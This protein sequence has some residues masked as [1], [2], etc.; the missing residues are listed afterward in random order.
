MRI[1]CNHPH[2]G[3][4]MEIRDSYNYLG[5]IF[6][7]QRKIDECRDNNLQEELSMLLKKLQFQLLTSGENNIS[8]LNSLPQRVFWKNMQRKY[9]GC[10]TLVASDAGL[11]DPAKIIGK[12]DEEI[13][14]NF[15]EE[16]YRNDDEW[17]LK[18]GLS[19]YN[20]LQ[21]VHTT[22]GSKFFLCN[23]IPLRDGNGKLVGI[24]GSLEDLTEFWGGNELVY[25]VTPQ[26]R[27]EDR[28]MANDERFVNKEKFIPGHTEIQKS[29]EGSLEILQEMNVWSGSIDCYKSEIGEFLLSD[30]LS[31]DQLQ[32]MQDAFAQANQVASIIT[33]PEGTPLT[34]PSNFSELCTQIRQ[35]EKGRQNCNF[36]DKCLGKKSFV[37]MTPVYGKCKGCGLIDGCAPIVIAGV[38]IANWII[39][40]N[41]IGDVTE[42]DILYY[43]IEIGANKIKM[44][45]A[46]TKMKQVSAK[47]FHDSLH[48]LWIMAKEIG[49]MGYKNLKLAKDIELRKVVEERY[50]QAK[51]K[52]E[53]SDRLK[54][55]FLANMSHE[56]R[57]PM[58]GILGFTALLNNPRLN[59]N[60]RNEY[61]NLVNSSSQTLLNLIDDI[62]DISKIETG[63]LIIHENKCNLYQLLHQLFGIFKD[64]V[65]LKE[66]NLD[67]TIKVAESLQDL[68]IICD[69]ARLRQIFSNLLSNA[70]KFTEKGSIEF[71]YSL[72][73]SANGRDNNGS[74][75]LFFVKDSG[76]GIHDDQIPLIFDVFRQI[77]DSYTRKVGGTGLGL[78][79]S[80]NLV[81]MLGGEI[82]VD[83][84][85]ELG[86]TFY[87]TIPFHKGERNS[88]SMTP[89][90]LIGRENNINWEKKVIL[91]A[92]DE[93]I[94]FLY[95]NTVLKRTKA[96]IY[97]VKNG[98]EAV[99]W[100]KMNEKIDIVLMDIKMPIM[101]G[102][103]ATQEIRKFKPAIP[104][105]AQTAYAMANEK[106]L[107]L[108]AGCNAYLSK[109]IRK[110]DLLSTIKAFLVLD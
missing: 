43:A 50:I 37:N 62:I 81:N 32:E 83:S 22:N 102:Y 49:T 92:E 69:Y 18:F 7:I 95:L 15:N 84:K 80:K 89:S 38:H 106:T 12:S 23:K 9:M 25:N 61:W 85:Q 21:K 74:S 96:S 19:K 11:D 108:M 98:K 56:I 29:N 48:L 17:I 60:K 103:E 58:N 4:K 110:D 107:C 53:E 54:S 97:W 101:N 68:V 99:E 90:N 93:E 28:L 72:L 67:F 79:I 41:F 20:Y 88:R 1:P 31:L 39:G 52:A 73:N 76:I 24:L 33:T 86:S 26:T 78:S 47:N 100:C 2:L 13:A 34:R 5:S 46:F 14:W 66:K 104:I 44:L 77:D 45:A 82:W 10:S 64:N 8:L 36:S 57:T 63:Q 70:I 109:P 55:A 6:A 65:L 75:V 40:Q 42:K 105:I 71:G 30:I 35:T 51:E 27:M 59:E 87:F 91:I 94:N 3:I 16:I